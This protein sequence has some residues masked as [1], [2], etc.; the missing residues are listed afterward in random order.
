MVYF[1]LF[2]VKIEHRGRL[3]SVFSVHPIPIV[4]LHKHHSFSHF[5]DVLWKA[6]PKQLTKASICLLAS[7]SHSH[8]PTN[9]NIEASQ[10][11]GFLV[12]NCNE[13]DVV[14]VYVCVVDWRNGNSN[15]ESV[16]KLPP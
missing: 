10:A 8:P 4:P 9:E 5:A 13:T 2:H 14:S 16:D 15:F 12:N 6:K 11:S 7:M 3:P 1:K